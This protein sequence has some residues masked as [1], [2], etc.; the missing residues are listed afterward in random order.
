[1]NGLAYYGIPFGTDGRKAAG[2]S[3]SLKHLHGA[4]QCENGD[5]FGGELY[6]AASFAGFPT[7]GNG[8]ADFARTPWVDQDEIRLALDELRA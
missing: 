8:H 2:Y 5:V 1:M 7:E 3:R 4:I 6:P